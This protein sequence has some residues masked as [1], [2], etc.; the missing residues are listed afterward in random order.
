MQYGNVT[1]VI[2]K[3]STSA[4]IRS[5]WGIHWGFITDEFRYQ[6][7]YAVAV[8]IGADTNQSQKSSK[9]RTDAMDGLRKE[10]FLK[11]ILVSDEPTFHHNN[12][13]SV[14]QI[15][16]IL[17]F[18]PETAGMDMKF[19]DHLC[20]LDYSSNL[21]GPHENMNSRYDIWIYPDVKYLEICRYVCFESNK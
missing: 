2:W 17:Y 20:K 15:D 6:T 11:S 13:T 18:I 10:F 14:S 12:Q 7:T 1:N 9:R 5:R 3:H 4:N 16:T 21:S 19:L 8:F